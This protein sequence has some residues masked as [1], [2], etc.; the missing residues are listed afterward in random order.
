MKVTAKFIHNKPTWTH[1]FY[2]TAFAL[3]LLVATP[4]VAMGI[5]SYVCVFVGQKIV[6][7]MKD[8]L[9]IEFEL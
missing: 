1:C 2:Y 5:V 9:D 7:F 4:F 3:C 8:K 6:Q